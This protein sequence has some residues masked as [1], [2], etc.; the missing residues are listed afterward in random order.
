[1]K[2]V[3]V[4]FLDRD[5]VI[6][7]YPGHYKYVESVAEFHLLPKVREA[8]LRLISGGY[9]LFI[10]S[11]QAGVGKGLYSQQTL[12]D[13]TSAMRRQLGNDVVFDGIFYCTHRPDAN[14]AC[15]KPK[16]AFIDTAIAQLEKAG[17][18]VDK[19]RSFFVG[20]S[21]IDMEIGKAAGLRTIMVFSGRE[22]PDNQKAWT[23]RP[24]STAADLFQAVDRILY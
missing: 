19:A 23:T 2:K 8:L 4:V 3:S 12:D 16:T 21:V 13:I 10:I 11:N 20:D 18:E 1:M 6:N 24:D 17:L 22:S 9:R 15:R 14:C 5:G 7:E